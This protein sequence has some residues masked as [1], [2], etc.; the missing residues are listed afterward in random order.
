MPGL[1]ILL[2][3]HTKLVTLKL[4]FI[5]TKLYRVKSNGSVSE[6]PIAA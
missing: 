4:N 2:S 5:I 1:I 6:K 3:P